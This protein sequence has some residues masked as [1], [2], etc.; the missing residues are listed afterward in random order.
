MVKGFEYIEDFLVLS[1][2]GLDF[3]LEEKTQKKKK[4]EKYVVDNGR[5]SGELIEMSL[6]FGIWSL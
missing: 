1:F 6:D 4:D 5:T 3:K 2:L